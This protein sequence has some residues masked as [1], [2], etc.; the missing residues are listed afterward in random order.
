M[1]TR[2]RSAPFFGVL[3]AVGSADAITASYLVLFAS[4][5]LR[6][7]PVEVGVATSVFT[8]SG[9]GCGVVAARLVDRS[10][11]RRPLVVGL[12]VGAAGFAAFPLVRGFLPL[13]A[14][15][16]FAGAINIG[17]PQV[18]ALERM[19]RGTASAGGTA[20]LRGTWSTAWAVG[21]VLA[22]AVVLTAG[23]PALFAAAAVLLGAAALGVRAFP[24]P[25]ASAR[26]ED[27]GPPPSR[28]TVLVPAAAV[29]LFHAAM[30][31]GSFVLPLQI[32]RDLHASSGWVGVVFGV[33]AAVEVGVSLL[34]AAVGARLPSTGGLIA[35]AGAF[36]LYFAG[37][38]LAPDVGWVLGLQLLRGFAIAAMGILGID[39]LQ[40]LLAPHLASATALFANA[41]AVGSLVAGVIGGVLAQGI[42]L[43]PTLA[44]C[45]GLAALA[46]GCLAVDALRRRSSA[47]REPVIAGAR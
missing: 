12:L 9:I 15:C 38:A 11:S 4:D 45:G 31:V 8:L 40:R 16:A 1:S 27:A 39:L 18:L 30:F 10:P 43:R 5:R 17:F 46:T 24:R 13:L 3:A 20:L 25:T 42:G 6:L 33:C 7:D 36:V 47:H 44:V 19:S 14:A 34:I 22:G 29:L 2:A 21:P 32:T 35:A 26:R 23:Y 28:S 37:M 41:L